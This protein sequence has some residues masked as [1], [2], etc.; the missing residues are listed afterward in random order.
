MDAKQE[1]CSHF[2]FSRRNHFGFK[3]S[4]CSKKSVTGIKSVSI[5]YSNFP[6]GEGD[7][8]VLF[9]LPRSLCLVAASCQLSCFFGLV[10]V[11]VL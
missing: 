11:V 10:C 5:F 3:I 6:E 9:F 8:E 4:R 2:R 7:V 1:V